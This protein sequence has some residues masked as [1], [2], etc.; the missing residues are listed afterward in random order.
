MKK[1]LLVIISL[2]LSTLCFSQG[3][4]F[5]QGTWRD[6]LAKA[7]QT[8]KPVFVDVY[9]SWCGPCKKMSKEVFPLENVGK[10]YNSNFICYQIDAEKGE[11]ISLSK[12]Y[13]VTAYPTYLF[14]KADGTLFFKTLGS[15]EPTMFME[16]S[17]KSLAE[18]NDP[19]SLVIWDK[20]YP[21]KK[22]DPQFLLDY[23]G[24]RARVGMS[25]IKLFN[26]YLS[27]IPES[28]R[29]SD[30]V[31]KLYRD[32][33]R[34]MKVNDFAFQYLLKNREKFI[35]NK[36]FGNVDVFIQNVVLNTTR[37][38]A[39]LKDEALLETALS[40]FEQ[41]PA[42]PALKCKEEIYMA[43]YQKTKEVDKYV[44]YATLFCDN[45]LMSVTPDSVINKDSTN[46]EMFEKLS[47]RG[48]FAKMD[49]T[50]LPP[51][52]SYAAHSERDKISWGL[53]NVAWEVFQ[54]VSDANTLQK[55]L[56]W[57]ER[58]LE[59]YPDNPMLLDTYANLLYKLGRKAEAIQKEKEA[60]SAAKDDQNVVV[61]YEDTI[62]KMETGEKTWQ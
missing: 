57:S 58:S 15:M 9:T 30:Q 18:M 36:F 11:G 38:A 19:K 50:M 23:M 12:K 37:E 54:K 25:N 21:Q 29:T 2:F 43:Y 47:A 52:K 45:H 40:A 34:Q 28:E 1:Q 3:I 53:N 51:L 31:V 5:E 61:G 60:L 39:Q 59:L 41:I 44:K 55:A 17:K 56:C 10:I 22:T 24:K 20:E 32:E 62:R 13:E 33:Q 8:G 4:E 14:I 6:V 42:T 49:S 27:L 46:Q 16:L 26:E 7:K 48:A 35:S